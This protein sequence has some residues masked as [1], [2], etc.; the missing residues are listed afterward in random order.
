MPK[1]AL[2]IV[3]GSPASGKTTFAR[4]VALATGATFLDIDATTETLV[5]AALSA[6][7]Q[8][9]D[10]RDSA[11][12]KTNF[13]EPIYQTL[14][15]IA[16]ENLPHTSVVIAGPFTREFANPHWLDEMATHYQ[17]SAKII[18]AHVHCDPTSRRLRMESR[19]NPR[20]AS[21]LTDW[22]AHAAYYAES[23]PAFPHIDVPTDD[24]ER[25]KSALAEIIAKF[26]SKER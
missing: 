2:L 21:K 3:V 15:E 6:A 10:D 19:G 16:S 7:N 26:P 24:E 9:P 22:D 1:N 17:L 11:F 4:Q 12:F 14:F 25:T 8:N 13:R 18:A 23:Q 20:D 5:R